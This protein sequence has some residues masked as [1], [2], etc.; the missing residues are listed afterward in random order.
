MHDI[1]YGSTRTRYKRPIFSDSYSNVQEVASALRAAGLVKGCDE[2]RGAS[3][4]SRRRGSMSSSRLMTASLLDGGRMRM[5]RLGIS[6]RYIGMIGGVSFCNIRVVACSSEIPIL[7]QT[8]ISAFGRSLHIPTSTVLAASE[9]ASLAS[10]RY[11]V[12]SRTK[13]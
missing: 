12:S 7:L 5:G 11:P 10:S 13:A 4:L 9:K 6:R 2:A 3:I 1:G 8:V